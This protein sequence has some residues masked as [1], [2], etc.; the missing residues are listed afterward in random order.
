MGEQVPAGSREGAIQSAAKVWTG[1]L[2]D[3]TARNNLLFYRDL[4]VGTLDL[5]DVAPDHLM[6]LLAGRTIVLSRLFPDEEARAGALKRARAV[7]N[8]AGALRGARPGDALSGV[9]H[10]DLDKSA[11]DGDSR[12]ARP[13]HPGAVGAARR[14]A[15]RV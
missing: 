4:K 3:L 14:G 1:Q 5:G 9:R 2:V 13:S 6:D 15:G 10:G 12:G 11:R 7:R 8:R